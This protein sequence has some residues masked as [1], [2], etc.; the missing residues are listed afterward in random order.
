MRLLTNHFLIATP[1]LRDSDFERTVILVCQHNEDGALGIVINR[2]TGLSL[3]DIFKE[4]DLEVNDKLQL[5]M[6]VHYGGPV[7]MDRGFVLHNSGNTWEATLP[8]GRDFGLTMSKDV[9]EA[10]S[11]QQGPEFCM[12]LLGISGWDEGQ[13]EEEISENLWLPVPCES[14][15]IISTPIN[16]RWQAAANLAGIDITSMS[17]IVGHA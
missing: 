12:P 5:K 6:P 3:G 10:M 4:L 15:I 13:L 16:N 1:A 2:T 9:L 14:S 8:I 7:Q 17:T 11:N